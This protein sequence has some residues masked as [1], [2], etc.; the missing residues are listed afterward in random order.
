M[1]D[2]SW[3]G[4]NVIDCIM[5]RSAKNAT[6][7]WRTTI[8][9]VMENASMLM[10]RRHPECNVIVS[11]V[12]LALDVINVSHRM[13]ISGYCIIINHLLNSRLADQNNRH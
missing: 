7:V 3:V 6:N 1:V 11:W 10:L 13:M 4:V 8:V 2:I 12:G 9:V 5:E